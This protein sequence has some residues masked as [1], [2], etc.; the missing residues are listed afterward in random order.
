[1]QSTVLQVPL[2]LALVGRAHYPGIPN[3][4]RALLTCTGRVTGK[5]TVPPKLNTLAQKCPDPKRSLSLEVTPCQSG[6]TPVPL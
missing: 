3:S 2:Y 4:R 6:A 5:R 1:M